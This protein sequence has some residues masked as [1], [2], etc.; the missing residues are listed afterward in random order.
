MGQNSA[1]WLWHN[2]HI[3][4]AVTIGYPGSGLCKQRRLA[5][6]PRFPYL[7]S[8]P[9]LPRTHAIVSS[10]TWF[11][12]IATSYDLFLSFP[13]PFLLHI[14]P[15]SHP[16]GFTGCI[17]GFEISDQ[18]Q[19][20]HLGAIEIERPNLCSRLPWY[21]LELDD[22]PRTPSISVICCIPPPHSTNP[23]S[24]LSGSA[25]IPILLDNGFTPPHGVQ[26]GSDPVFDSDTPSRRAEK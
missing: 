3:H 22:G 5:Q 4:E 24:T 15:L 6:P 26:L 1:T 10:L 11:F 19:D 9:S 16:R 18:Y 2:I 17:K 13:L 25:A 21:S 12:R 7:V 20:F 8:I 23:I 14:P